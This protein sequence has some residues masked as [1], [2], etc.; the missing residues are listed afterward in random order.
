MGGISAAILVGGRSR[1]MGQN[2]ALLQMGSSTLLEHIVAAAAPVVDELALIARRPDDF[3][4]L[5]LPVRADLHPDLGPLGGLYTALEKSTASTILLLPCD[6]P[7]ITPDFLRFIIDHL[8]DHEAAI[9]HNAQG[10]Q[11]LCAAYSRTCLPAVKAALAADRLS[12]R[13]LHRDIDAR[14]LDADEWR[15]LDPDQ[16]L[17]MNINTPADYEHARQIAAQ[18]G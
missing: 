4:D 3:A 17:F 18:R 7:F 11:P 10:L 16:I 2:K 12:I 15:H 9:P 14:I 13:A 8:G 6:L 5:D 1:R